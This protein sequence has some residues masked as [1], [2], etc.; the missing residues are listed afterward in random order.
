MNKKIRSSNKGV[1]VRTEDGEVYKE[2]DTVC[3][4][5]EF[6]KKTKAVIYNRRAA[7]NRLFLE[8]GINLKFQCANISKGS[9]TYEVERIEQLLGDKEEMKLRAIETEDETRKRLGLNPYGK[10]R[11]DIWMT[12]M[13]ERVNKQLYPDGYDPRETWLAQ[14]ANDRASKRTANIKKEKELEEVFYNNVEDFDK[15]N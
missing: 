4:C 3:D 12:E 6:F 2:F 9:Y 11:D 5:A 10:A 15:D 14:R 13:F 7:P 8:F 1:V